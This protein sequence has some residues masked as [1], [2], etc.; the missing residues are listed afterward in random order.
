MNAVKVI[1]K[2]NKFAKENSGAMDRALNAMAMDI[3]RASKEV[4]PV[5][6]GELKASGH[7]IKLSHL[8]WEVRYGHYGPS[9]PYARY[10]E[11]GGDGRRVVRHYS[12]PGKK[13]HYLRDAGVIV[14]RKVLDY[15]REQANGI[16]I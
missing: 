6:M 15:I 16:R 3:E 4:V 8:N 14:S 7:H 11:F 13:A 2:L 12:Q 10:Q 9:M 1:N 5:A